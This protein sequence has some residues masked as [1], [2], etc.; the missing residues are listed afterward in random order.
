MLLIISTFVVLLLAFGF[1]NRHKR[2]IHIP[3]M[4]S[5]F[6][7]DL[8]LV[9][10]IELNRHAV[11]TLITHSNAF[12]I[13]HVSV[14]TLVLVLYVMLAVVGSKMAKLTTGEQLVSLTS[15]HVTLARIFILF[16]LTNYVTSFSMVS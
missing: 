13:F 7:I 14:S 1:L 11:E 6:V 5:A 8:G 16:R 15:K 12:M 2:H 4:A 10:Y 3:V 9:I